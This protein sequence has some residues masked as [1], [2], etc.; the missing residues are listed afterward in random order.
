MS[1]PVSFRVIR[2][3][4]ASYANPIRVCKGDVV[5]L[6]GKTDIW[7]GPVHDHVWLWGQDKAGRE[8]WLPSD[9]VAAAAGATGQWRA[10]RGYWAVELTCRVGARLVGTDASHGWVWCTDGDGGAGW[11]PETCLR[12]LP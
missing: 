2:A 9:L 4:T 11:V 5:T 10:D 1:R 7:P 6:S 12:Q 3:H 8:G